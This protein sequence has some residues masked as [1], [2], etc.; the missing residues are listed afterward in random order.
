MKKKIFLL[1]LL[2]MLLTL[3]FGAASAQA[4]EPEEDPFFAFVDG[5]LR[6]RVKL[7]VYLMSNDE[8]GI[9]IYGVDENSLAEKAG[10]LPGDLIISVNGEAP[11]SEEGLI[12]FLDSSKEGDT[13]TL[14]ILRSGSQVTSEITLD[15]SGKLGITFRYGSSPH[16]YALAEDGSAAKAGLQEGDLILLVDGYPF[17][18]VDEVTEYVSR[19]AVGDELALSILRGG[20]ILDV[21]VVPEGSGIYMSDTPLELSIRAGARGNVLTVFAA[22]DIPMDASCDWDVSF[23]NDDLEEETPTGL[24][25]YTEYDEESGIYLIMLLAEGVDMNASGSYV[26]QINGEDGILMQSPAIYITVY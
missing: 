17:S 16:V 6:E 10:L 9:R 8:Y 5:A 18:S 26:L 7:G 11:E 2:C 12:E 14:G 13:L 1:V 3:C 23:F 20:E 25:S 4:E 15:G 24:I 21:T 19:L 22:G